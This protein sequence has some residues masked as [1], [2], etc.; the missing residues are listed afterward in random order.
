[1]IL[2]LIRH[3]TTDWNAQGRL[4]GRVDRPLAPGGR[5]EVAT[6]RLPPDLADADRQTSPL[7]RAR[8]TAR[9]LFGAEVPVEPRL[10]EMAWGAWEGRTI[11]DLKA[12][13]GLDFAAREARGLD[14]QP[15]AGESPRQLQARLRPWLAERAAAG[16]DTVA[17]THHGV[18]R[19]VLALAT[20]WNMIGRGPGKLHRGCAHLFTLAD[21][22][23][24]TLHRLNRKLTP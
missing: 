15:P 8:E 18:A 21:D 17:I 24:L 19:A 3:A 10:I 20:G 12:D 2:A 7:A 4:Q 6:W 1:M 13:P 23:T 16:R 9:L 11:A 5:A 22:G 14:F